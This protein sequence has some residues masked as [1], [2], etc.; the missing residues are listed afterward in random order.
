M[1]EEE[2][3]R[4]AR[5]GNTAAA[6]EASSTSDKWRHRAAKVSGTPHPTWEKMVPG[7]GRY[8]CCIQ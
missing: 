3:V 1:A 4:L 2:A 8:Y 5:Q 6:G 7:D